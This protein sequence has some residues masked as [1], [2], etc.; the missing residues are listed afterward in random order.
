MRLNLFLAASALSLSMAVGACAS[1][2]EAPVVVQEQAE[3]PTA[4]PGL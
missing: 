3:A 1:S 2:P 4:I